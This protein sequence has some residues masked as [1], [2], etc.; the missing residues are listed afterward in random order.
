MKKIL[1]TVSGIVS[2]VGFAFAQTAPGQGLINLLN[3]AQNITNR[4]IPILMGLGVAALF[5]GLVMYIWKG[6]EDKV[7][8]EKWMKFIGASIVA[9]FVMVSIWGLVR[10]FGSIVGVD[11]VGAPNPANLIPMPTN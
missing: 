6:R 11:A 9:I 8:H 2:S 10:F 1:T 4:L 7:E 3:L 5:F